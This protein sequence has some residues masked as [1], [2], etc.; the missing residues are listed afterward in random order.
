MHLT[1]A[2]AEVPDATGYET[3]AFREAILEEAHRS[4][5]APTSAVARLPD[6]MVAFWNSITGS[7]PWATIGPTKLEFGRVQTG[8]L[9]A[10]GDRKFIS[11]SPAMSRNRVFL[12]LRELGGKARVTARVCSV[13]LG[14]HYEKLHTLTVNETPEERDDEK[15]WI[16]QD[17]G[18]LHRHFLIV[19][20]DAAGTV[21]RNF[22]Y[23]LKAE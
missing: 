18:D 7:D 8:N 9:I 6:K 20:L 15:Q 5:V 23:E 11:S 19:Y 22:R 17:L 21:T 12:N 4:R 16:L 1:R 13:S 14:N 10:P 2:A 3:M